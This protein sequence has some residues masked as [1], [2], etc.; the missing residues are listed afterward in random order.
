VQD[1]YSGTVDD[2]SFGCKIYNSVDPGVGRAPVSHCQIHFLVVN[3]NKR[4]YA[5]SCHE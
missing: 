2:A 3:A 1:V 4:T 5:L